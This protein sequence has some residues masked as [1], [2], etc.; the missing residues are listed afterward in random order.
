MKNRIYQAAQLFDISAHLDESEILNVKCENCELF[1]GH[2]N[3]IV[4]KDWNVYDNDY[5]TEIKFYCND[6]FKHHQRQLKHKQ[7]ARFSAMNKN[8]DVENRH[9]LKEYIKC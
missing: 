9:R 5:T 7:Q 3:F 4:S 6:C 2:R 1:G 8:E